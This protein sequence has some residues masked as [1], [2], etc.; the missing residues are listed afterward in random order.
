MVKGYWIAHVSVTDADAYKDYIAANAAALA[1]FG[2]HFLIRAGRDTV[3]EPPRR[4]V[5]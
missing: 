2:G 4:G 5:E 1:R 3:A